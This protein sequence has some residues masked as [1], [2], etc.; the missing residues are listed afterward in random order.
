LDNEKD[1]DENVN[2]YGNPDY[3]RVTLHLA[4]KLKSYLKEQAD[5]L[6]DNSEVMKK[7]NHALSVQ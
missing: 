1:P 3:K 2:Y 5:P 4:Q 7:L 6:Q